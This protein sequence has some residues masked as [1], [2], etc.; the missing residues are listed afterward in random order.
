MIYMDN[1]ATTMHK[2]QEVI[3]AVVNCYELN[4]P[5][6]AAVQVRRHSV[7][8]GLSMIQETDWR[9]CLGQKMQDGLHLLRIRQRV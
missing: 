4:G 7:H 3:D 9:N 5:M 6:P 1:A 8:P 2:P